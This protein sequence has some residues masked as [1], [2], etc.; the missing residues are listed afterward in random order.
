MRKLKISGKIISEVVKISED[1]Y[2]EIDIFDTLMAALVTP[3]QK[4][5]ASYETIAASTDAIR[6]LKGAEGREY[7][8]LEKVEHNVVVLALKS[9]QFR[10][11]DPAIKDWIDGIES[12][13]DVKVEEIAA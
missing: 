10:F 1:K 5:G 7:V 13:P 3:N 8:L 6:K 11:N 12:L 2:F 4:T 9:L